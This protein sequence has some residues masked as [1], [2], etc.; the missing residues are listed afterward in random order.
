MIEWIGD[1]PKNAAEE[2]ALLAEFSTDYP[3]LATLNDDEAAAVEFV[4]FM[5][6]TTVWLREELAQPRPTE[7]PTPWK[8]EECLAR[9]SSRRTRPPP[10]ARSAGVT[11]RAG[12]RPAG[13]G[14]TMA[15]HVQST[16]ALVVLLFVGLA[17]LDSPD[18]G[19]V[20]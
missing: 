8:T 5:R 19:P 10:R 1:N 15:F 20:F 14:T 4:P 17:G 13:L 12:A 7:P 18:S 16:F 6:G 11:S 9:P 3:S 2:D